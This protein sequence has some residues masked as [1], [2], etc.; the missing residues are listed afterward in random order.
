MSSDAVVDA[1]DPFPGAPPDEPWA[2]AVVVEQSPIATVLVDVNPGQR[3]RVLY[4]NA[5]A[6]SIFASLSPFSAD[7][8]SIAGASLFDVVEQADAPTLDER[9]DQLKFGKRRHNG[10]TAPESTSLTVIMPK[11][12]RSGETLTLHLRPLSE[13]I[14]IVQL[15]SGVAVTS[16]E[17]VLVEQQRF[18]TALIELTELA[19]ST[20]D[21]NDFYQRLIERA[22]EVVPGAQGGSVQL[23]LPGTASFRFVAAS[24]YDLAGLQLHDLQRDHF[25][26]DTFN[27][28]AQI[29]REFDIEGRSAQVTEWLETCG[30]LSEIVVNVS[31]PVLDDGLPIAFLSLDN[32]DDPDGFNETSI[33][34]T[35]VLSRLIGSL[36][37][38]RQLES[39]LRREREAFRHEALHDPLTGLPNRRSLERLMA[40]SLENA[41][42][43]GHPSAVLFIDLDDFKGVNDRLGHEVG[44]LLLVGVANGLKDVVRVGDVV[45]RWGGDEFLAYPLRL[46]SQGTAQNLADRILERFEQDLVLESGLQYR[47]RLTVGI[48]WSP[49]SKTTATQLVSVADAALYEA[50]AAGKGVHRLLVV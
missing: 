18:R 47:A 25:F 42:G 14:A 33:E 7:D 27:P 21:D 50:K 43:H 30:R 17:Q 46:E 10:E 2:W 3:G 37:R 1:S 20:R 44:D 36:W 45:G 26:R 49:D 34:M 6:S 19:Y 22:V 29:V 39:E 41:I 28:I 48:G 23:N 31:A 35:T 11:T 9:F 4:G 24:G 8:G 12:A 16:P 5:A 15:V 13:S 32:F 38:R 40:G